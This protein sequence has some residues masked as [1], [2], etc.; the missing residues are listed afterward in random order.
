MGADPADRSHRYTEYHQYRI[1]EYP[2][3]DRGDRHTAGDRHEC[4]EP[5]Q[6]LSVGRSLLWH[7][8][9]GHREC[10]RVSVHDPRGVGWRG[11]VSS[12]CP[13]AGCDG[14]SRRIVDRSLPARDSRSAAADREDE[15]CG[16]DRDAGVRDHEVVK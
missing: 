9:G 7:L 8:C 2:Y 12:D 10:S 6:D 1:Y 13:S 3:A 4:G 5:V 14:G 16:V 11:R 15:H